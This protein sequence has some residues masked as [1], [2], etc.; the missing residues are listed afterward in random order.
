MAARG[1]LQKKCCPQWT[2]SASQ[3]QTKWN[4]TIHSKIYIGVHTE[5]S[6]PMTRGANKVLAVNAPA[7]RFHRVR[8]QTHTER[9]PGCQ[10][11][12]IVF[13]RAAANTSQRP[14]PP[15]IFACSARERWFSLC[16]RSRPLSASQGAINNA[17]IC[18]Q[19]ALVFTCGGEQWCNNYYSSSVLCG[20]HIARVIWAPSYNIRVRSVSM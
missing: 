17:S 5:A 7:C 2:R 20:C 9:V 6:F 1:T 19:T 8:H 13:T 10:I 12:P 18:R 16:A 14:A 11:I 4:Y 15:C 3:L